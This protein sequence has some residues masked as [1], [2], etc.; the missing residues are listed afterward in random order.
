MTK[1]EEKK[2]ASIPFLKSGNMKVHNGGARFPSSLFPTSTLTRH[3]S[4]NEIAKILTKVPDFE[5]ILDTV[6]KESN[7]FSYINIFKIGW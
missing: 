7:T 5:T 2:D 3:I 1:Y 4:T 6:K